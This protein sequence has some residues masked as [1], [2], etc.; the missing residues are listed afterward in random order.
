MLRNWLGTC[1]RW[2][3]SI[4]AS[5]LWFSFSSLPRLL[6]LLNNFYLTHTISCFY[7]S[8]PLSPSHCVVLSSLQLSAHNTLQALFHNAL[9]PLT[10]ATTTPPEQRGKDVT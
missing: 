6:C 2:W 3:V 1:G 8:F 7:S 9:Q 5:L 10:H 4:F